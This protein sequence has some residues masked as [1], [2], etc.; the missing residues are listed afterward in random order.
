MCVARCGRLSSAHFITRSPCEVALS[1]KKLHCCIPGT[2]R[3][4]ATR[5]APTSLGGFRF[6][7]W[8]AQSPRRQTCFSR[9]SS[10][11]LF[12]RHPRPTWSTSSRGHQP[13]PMVSMFTVKTLV[14]YI[15]LP[16]WWMYITT[17]IFAVVA[18]ILVFYGH[19]S[20]G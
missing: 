1:G 15:H 18:N 4:H 7:D 13:L 8:F 11:L 17:S 14:V 5:H 6:N 19:R 3:S 16:L 9:A 20:G 10:W 2:V 12:R